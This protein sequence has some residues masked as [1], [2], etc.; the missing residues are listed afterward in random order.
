MHELYNFRDTI[1]VT[2]VLR[3]HYDIYFR[4]V[5]KNN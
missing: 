1:F 5:K 4:Y 3:T 2:E